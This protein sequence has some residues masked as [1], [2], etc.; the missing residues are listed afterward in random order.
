MAYERLQE[1]ANEEF[2]LYWGPRCEEHEEG[3][4]VC[5]AYAARDGG[6]K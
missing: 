5:D 3:C 4:P 6:K 1:L 2:E